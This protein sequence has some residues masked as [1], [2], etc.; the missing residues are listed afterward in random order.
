MFIVHLA[1]ILALVGLNAFFVGAEY[2]LLSF[3]RSR[4]QQLVRQ[5]NIR[6]ALVQRLLAHPSL[7]FSGL[8]LGITIASLLLGWLGEGL[9]A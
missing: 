8:Q 2:A 7:L 5:G 4:L 3:R 9:L 6:A 1:I